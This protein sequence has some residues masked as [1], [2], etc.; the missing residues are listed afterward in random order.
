ML[1]SMQMGCEH[2]YDRAHA[3]GQISG[4]VQGP[5]VHERGLYRQQP[6]ASFLGWPCRARRATAAAAA[7]ASLSAGQ[8]GLAAWDASI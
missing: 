7:P 6:C 2:A 5:V 4:E 8:S 3:L 1:T